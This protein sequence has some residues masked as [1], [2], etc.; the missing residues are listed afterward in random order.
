MIASTSLS[1]PSFYFV[2]PL[3]LLVRSFLMLKNSYNNYTMNA[4]ISQKLG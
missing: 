3:V 4:V 1:N 2:F